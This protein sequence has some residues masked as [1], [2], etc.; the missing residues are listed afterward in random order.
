MQFKKRKKKKK[1]SGVA[2]LK[3]ANYTEFKSFRKSLKNLS[4]LEG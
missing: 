4:P 3:S 1:K 2:D